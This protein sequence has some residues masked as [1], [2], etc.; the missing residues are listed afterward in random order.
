MI[1]T[2]KFNGAE[3]KVELSEVRALAAQLMVARVVSQR[4]MVALAE[5]LDENTE[6]RK[7]ILQQEISRFQQEN[8]ITAKEHGLPSEFSGLTQD[9]DGAWVLM[10]ARK[11]A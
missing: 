10:A 9:E 4:Q 11:E 6:L 1:E 2:M 5:L 3:E 8:R 7:K